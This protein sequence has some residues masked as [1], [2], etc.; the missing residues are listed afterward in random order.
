MIRAE[1]EKRFGN[2]TAAEPVLG[3]LVASRKGN[4]APLLVE[5]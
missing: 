3:T 4:D 5:R 2:T 1:L